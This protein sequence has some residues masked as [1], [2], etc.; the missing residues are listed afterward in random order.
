M[1][2]RHTAATLE[3][4]SSSSVSI[5]PDDLLENSS[6]R[7]CTS[8]NER[9]WR[10]AHTRPRQEKAVAS[11]LYTN[12]IGFYLPLIM[13]KSV[14]RGR[15]RSAQIPLFPGYVFVFGSDDDRLAALK[16]N[17]LLTVQDVADGNRLREQLRQFA[18]LIAL[19]T[20]LVRESR[21]VHGDY[22][23]VKYGPFRGIE[24]KVLRRNGKTELQ[25]AVDFLQQG[26]ALEIDDCLLEAI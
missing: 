5:Y 9:T 1:H 24:G 16:T 26:A 2:H 10:L 4:T 20:P 23:R 13:R 3:R 14:T 25:V 21:L 19:N 12:R 15:L 6:S 7:T 22:V 8:L 18:R 11:T 17:R